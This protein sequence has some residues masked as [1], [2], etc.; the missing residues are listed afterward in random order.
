MQFAEVKQ[1]EEGAGKVDSLKGRTAKTIGRKKK[2]DE[3]T[4][5]D[6]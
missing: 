3:P 4:I 1:K 2:I 6:R 5:V